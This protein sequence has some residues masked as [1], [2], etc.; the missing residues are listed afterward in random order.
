MAT[1]AFSGATAPINAVGQKHKFRF[2]GT[3]VAGES[4]TTEIVSTLSGNFI[5]GKG[6]IAGQAYTYG[7]SLRDRAYLSL[8]SNFALSTNGDVTLWEEQDAGSAIVSY[9]S[10]FGQQD[11][12]RGFATM[13]GKLAVFAKYSIQIWQIDAD[14]ALFSLLQT[15][16][17]SGTIAS[18][19]IQSIGDL[20][21]YY[22]DRTGVRSLR[23]KEANLNA[24]VDDIGTPIDSLIRAD[25]VAIGV[26]Y[27]DD[28][29]ACSVIESTTKQYW[30]FLG[31]SIYVLSS[32]PGSKIQAWSRFLPTYAIDKTP[33]AANYDAGGLVTYT[34][35]LGRSYY[36]TKGAGE[37][38]LV[39]GSN[40][41][42]ESGGFDIDGLVATVTGTPFAVVAGTLTENREWAPVK[43]LSHGGQIFAMSSNTE[44]MRYGGADNT[45]YDH[46]RLQFELPWLDLKM[47][48]DNKQILAVDAA[49]SGDW[50]GEYGV[51]P[52][53]TSLFKVFDRGSPTS[54]LMVNDSTFDVG[55]FPVSG[56]GTHV[57][58]R[59]TCWNN[60]A[61]KFGKL[62]LVYNLGNKK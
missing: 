41:L 19:S 2:T 50:L 43:M 22:L 52:R 30:L 9:T 11:T 16:N 42:T 37:T 12:V 13:Q 27:V 47:I 32:F 46:C 18:L 53:G 5:L 38:Q 59:G 3:W 60:A 44:V 36:W 35:V 20:D 4:W 26:P 34:L 54:P 33:N 51:N 58:F 57:K 6:N 14:P 21:V 7:M 25:L 8:G 24:Y 39:N 10:Q 17:N 61:V 62:S 49:F 28:S 29:G 55:R 45:T 1:Y 23:T 40:V 15:L 56:F 31:T 48:S